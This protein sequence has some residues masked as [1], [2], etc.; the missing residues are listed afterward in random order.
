MF[1]DLRSAESDEDDVI[2]V[3]IGFEEHDPPVIKP[4]IQASAAQAK[5]A[6][7]PAVDAAGEDEALVDS[8]I[9]EDTVNPFEAGFSDGVS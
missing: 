5:N 9:A 6:Q 8:T 7:A 2:I 3:G 1:S 4:E